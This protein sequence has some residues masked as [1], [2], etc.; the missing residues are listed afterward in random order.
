MARENPTGARGTRALDTHE[1]DEHQ[2][3]AIPRSEL[4]GGPC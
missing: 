4:S 3:G 2:Q 1:E